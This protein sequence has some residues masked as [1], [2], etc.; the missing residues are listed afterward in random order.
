MCLSCGLLNIHPRTKLNMQK[1]D[2]N[3]NLK[4]SGLKINGVFIGK[5]N[6]SAFVLYENGV[7][8]SC[9]V[10]GSST[11]D[12]I[13]SRIN[14]RTLVLKPKIPS[15]VGLYGFYFNEVTNRYNIVIEKWEITGRVYDSSVRYQGV[16]MDSVTLYFKNKM[17][18]DNY[19][20][21]HKL[22]VKPDSTNSFIK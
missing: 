18:L 16:V 5:E 15:D 4:A 11:K 19:Y 21:L 9:G 12:D 7:I 1:K 6:N 2:Q 13:V 3:E 10:F 14:N 20:I 8:L 22:D 17:I